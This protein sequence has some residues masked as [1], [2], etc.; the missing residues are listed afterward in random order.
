MGEL[1]EAVQ[2]QVCIP[3]DVTSCFLRDSL[4]ACTTEGLH[5]HLMLRGLWAMDFAGVVLSIE[6]ATAGFTET[7]HRFLRLQ[8]AD[9]DEAVAEHFLMEESPPPDDAA[10]GHPPRHPQPEPSSRC[11]PRLLNALLQQGHA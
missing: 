7:G 8:V 11:V 4:L 5:P 10:G 9:V 2:R 1:V 6:C 3:C